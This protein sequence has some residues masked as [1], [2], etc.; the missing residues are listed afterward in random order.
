MSQ[1][2]RSDSKEA[3]A[4]TDTSESKSQIKEEKVISLKEFIKYVCGKYQIDDIFDRYESDDLCSSQ[5]NLLDELMSGTG[6]IKLT[7]AN[8]LSFKCHSILLRSYSGWF[9]KHQSTE[10]DLSTC[11]PEYV[12]LIILYAYF[13][14]AIYEPFFASNKKNGV[15][16]AFEKGIELLIIF[17]Q[18]EVEE[19]IY[20]ICSSMNLFFIENLPNEYVDPD[21]PLD[22][23]SDMVK[24][25]KKLYTGRYLTSF[26]EQKLDTRDKCHAYD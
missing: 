22:Q 18:Y 19:L 24:S 16:K 21:D 11:L 14:I 12:I 15:V 6:D 8:G 4:S 17:E 25:Y 5:K 23:F 20:D 3:K 26:L 2:N 1:Q 9:K 13:Q 7:L 10:I